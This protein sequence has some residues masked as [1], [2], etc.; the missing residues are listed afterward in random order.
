V[1]WPALAGQFWCFSPLPRPPLRP[2]CS[3]GFRIAVA[4]AWSSRATRSAA[5]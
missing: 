4:V 5:C 3:S 2:R 1:S